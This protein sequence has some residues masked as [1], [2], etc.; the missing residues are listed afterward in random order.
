MQSITS[1]ELSILL[2]EP[3]DTQ[4]KIIISELQQQGI[5][6][7][8]SAKSVEEAMAIMKR[9][10]HDLIASAMYFEQGTALDLLRQIR[11]DDKFTDTAFMLVTSE[12]KREHLEEF[13]QSGVVA[14]L[15]K[16]FTREH[17]T[18]AINNTLDLLSVDEME[19]EYFDVHEIRVLLVDDSRLARNHIKR[20]LNN[21][22]LQKVTEAVDGS[23]AI[24]LLEDNMFDL[25]VTDFNM[26]EVDGRELTRYIREQSQQSHLPVVMVTS[27]SQMAHLAN[28]EQDGVNALCDKPFEPQY[29]KKLLYGLLEH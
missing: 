14:L 27:E 16:P 24:K 17:L 1:K 18:S 13:K 28:I 23:H 22:G 3:S 4:R 29:V 8:S 21:L 15:P 6:E 19:L 9:H 5:D 12:H 25:V 26:P 20:V 11:A 7:I 10:P 2:V